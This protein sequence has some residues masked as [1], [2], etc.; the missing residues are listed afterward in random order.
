VRNFLSP[1]VNFEASDYTELIDWANCKLSTPPM[2]ENISIE[3]LKEL[4]NTKVITEFEFINF[5]CHTQSVERIVKLVTESSIKVCGEKNRDGFTRTT[6]FSRTEMPSFN[7]KK[8][9]ITM[10]KFSE[11]A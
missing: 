11:D 4:L 5:P 2:M 3:S 9:F 8:E 6:L 10:P 7:S 1:V